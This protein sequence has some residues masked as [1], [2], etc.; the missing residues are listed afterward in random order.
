MEKLFEYG[1]AIGE[2]RVHLKCD[3]KSAISVT[4]EEIKR[5]RED[6]VNYMKNHIE[7]RYSLKP[8][9]VS[10]DA[11]PII[12]IMAEAAE[13]A[14]VGPMAAVAGALADF[15]LEALRRNGSETALVEDGGEIAAYASQS[16]SV[17]VL[18]AS[19][20]VSG[21]F[22]FL[23]T[24]DD[25]PL[26]IATSSSKTGQAISFGEADSVTIVA[27]NAA[28]AD[29]AATAVG[30]SVAG[31]GIDRS[32]NLGLERAK[33]IRKVRGAVIIREGHTGLTGRLPKI[34]KIKE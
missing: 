2:S 27:D 23:V 11:P 34:I 30:N 15:G 4:V 17:E 8:V 1:L 28:V 24:L 5:H 9:R 3:N 31:V 10:A 13:I 20:T 21:K 26:G 7:F 12:R 22:G 14:D 29:A 18:S 32:I 16:L 6:L 19:Q 25:S 33:T